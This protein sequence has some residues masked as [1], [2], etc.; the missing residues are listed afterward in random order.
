[1]YETAQIIVYESRENSAVIWRCFSRDTKAELPGQLDGYP[2]T[3]IAPYAFSAHMESG[4]IER[5]LQ[6]GKLRLFVPEFLREEADG[7]K[8]ALQEKGSTQT[9]GQ[10]HQR[11]EIHQALE[12][13]RQVPALC[14]DA[15]EEVRIPESVRHVGRYC[16][17]NCAKLRKLTF[18]GLLSDWGSGVFTGCHQMQKLCVYADEAGKSY[19]K[20]VLDELPE[21]LMVAYHLPQ[22]DSDRSR[23]NILMQQDN[24]EQTVQ[25]ESVAQLVFPEFYEEGVEN[26]PAR[27]L[28][29][30]IHGSGI[31]YR[32][33]FQS[34]SFDFHQYDAIFPHA[35]AQEA[36][37]IVA[38]LVMGRLRYPCGLSES[39]R[40]QYVDYVSGHAQ[41]LAALILKERDISGLRWLLE[42]LHT[43]PEVQLDRLCDWM[44]QEATRLGFA[45]AVTVLMDDR[46][47]H[48]VVSG[49]K[50][51]LEL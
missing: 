23:Q 35:R 19:L 6:Q 37:E 17:Y 21:A 18:Y 45:E 47:R 31:R 51:R 8:A 11:I 2:V 9:P 22:K 34:R 43:Q 4:Q 40:T 16:F 28:E 49:K 7:A 30:H 14:G 13:I 1:M 24:P 50:K 25:G 48:R 32:N 27:I 20:D 46:R 10:E 3:G 26:T 42:L 33:C 38:R 15:L 39:A 29:T 36:P 41:E 44:T 12:Y 5:G